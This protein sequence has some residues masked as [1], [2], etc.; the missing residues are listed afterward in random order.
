MLAGA[1]MNIIERAGRQLGLKPTK[2]LVEMAAARL[3]DAETQVKSQ[4][5]LGSK[6]PAPLPR[7][8]QPPPRVQRAT[9]RQVAIDFDRLRRMGLALPG[10]QS[11]VAEEF[12]VIKRPLLSAAFAAAPS[13]AKNANVI[14]VTSA[15]PHEGK[16]FVA[17]N[18]ALSLASEHDLHVLLIDADFPH[19]EV[20]RVLG[21]ETESGLIDVV[22]EPFIDLADALIRTNIDNLSVLTSGPT[23]RG[24]TELLASARMV[25]F[26]DDIAA[27]YPDRIIIFDSP[28]VLARSEPIVLAR[29]VGQV[30]LVVEAERTPRAVIEEAIGMIGSERISGV[31]LNK[32]PAIVQDQFGS[33]YGAYYR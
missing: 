11:A 27:R 7:P 19:P 8:A 21:I 20:P 23:R 33:Y 32:A 1:R 28:P 5:P 17:V 31:V 30:V 15:R 25:S 6:E 3:A 4:A 16:T 10:D 24:A 9:R 12:R 26:V 13:R 22:S 2:S 18:L 14:L 29:H